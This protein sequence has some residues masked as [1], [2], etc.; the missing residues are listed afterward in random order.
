LFFSKTAAAG[1]GFL[2]YVLMSAN[3]TLD[4]IRNILLHEAHQS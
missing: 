2:F 3:T 4:D 1:F